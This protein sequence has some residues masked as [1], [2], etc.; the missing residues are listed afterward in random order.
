MGFNDF[1]YSKQLLQYMFKNTLKIF[2]S[3]CSDFNMDRQLNGSDLE[4]VLQRL[5]GGKLEKK[6]QDELVLKVLFSN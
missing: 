1:V 5:T 6:T 4:K 2:P 3:L